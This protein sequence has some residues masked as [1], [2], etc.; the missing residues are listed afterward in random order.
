MSCAIFIPIFVM[1]WY[2]VAYPYPSSNKATL[3]VIKKWAYLR[4]GLN[5]LVFY[6]NYY[7]NASEICPDK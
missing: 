3:S 4:G 2:T 6:A 1:Y 7:L 5:I